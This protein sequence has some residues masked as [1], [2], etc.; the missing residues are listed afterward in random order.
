MMKSIQNK[1]IS[2]KITI[3]FAISVLG[4]LY[5]SLFASETLAKWKPTQDTSPFDLFNHDKHHEYF[6]EYNVDC[7]LCHKTDDSYNREKV[8]KM[9]C[10]YCH[11]NDQSPAPKAAR[12]KCITCHKDLSKVMPNDHKLNW[13]SRHQTQAKQK[14]T[15]CLKCHKGFFC[16]DCH[17]K[18]DDTNKTRHSRLFRY[19]HSIEARSNPKS[20]NN[21]H[22]VS[23]CKDCHA[24]SQ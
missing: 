14:K 22:Q 11:N 2:H 6:P 19:S 3:V 7:T 4:F 21:C 18:R 8:E 10:H 24:Q 5:F 17:Q 15:A 20:C 16:T 9:G 23:F 12:Y 13:I 1:N